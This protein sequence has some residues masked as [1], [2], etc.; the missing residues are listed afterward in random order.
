MK[1][2]NFFP[3]IALL[4]LSLQS[5][6]Q[7]GYNIRIDVTDAKDQTLMLSY[8]KGSASQHSLIDSLPITASRQTVEL[9][10][11][12]KIIGGIYQL[13]FK[14]AAKNN[15]NIVVDNGA[16]LTFDLQGSTLLLLKPKDALSKDF[17]LFQTATHSFEDKN[18]ALNQ[19]IQ[20]YPTSAVALFAHLELKKTAAELA[21]ADTGSIS[22][23]NQYF[24]DIDL[25]DKRLPL[26]PN[27]YSFLFDYMN[28]LPINNENYQDNV[29]LF[30]KNMDCNSRNYMFYLDWVFKNLTY[31]QRYELT[32]TYRYVYS[33]YLDKEACKKRDEKFY[34]KMT[35][36][37][38]ALDQLPIGTVIPA[39]DMEDST[40]KEYHSQEIYPRS[41]YTFL[42]FYDPDCSHCQEAMPKVAAYFEAYQ[43]NT[44]LVQ[45][46]AFINSKD[47]SKWYPFIQQNKLQQ[48]LNVKAYKGDTKYLNDLK[49]FA[50]PQF[51]LLDAKGTI[52][53]KRFNT[54][55]LNTILHKK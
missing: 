50:N 34:N 5:L 26:M 19:L 55:E 7:D 44:D 35:E 12:D 4:L 14:G 25:Q 1:P 17:I 53:L 29:D 24:K 38:K 13:S 31:Y 39:F 23:R 32:N 20:K 47:V 36:S 8:F 16:R 45:Q 10:S 37:L 30:F 33:M 54:D 48:W 11:A 51:F 43:P 52:L 46:V 22:T 21:K 9:K 41:K 3:L 28:L 40:G 15:I 27:A 49:V 6:A 2:V 18:T 42:A